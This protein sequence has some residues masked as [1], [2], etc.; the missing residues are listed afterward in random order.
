MTLA[1]IP[2]FDQIEQ[3][4]YWGLRMLG[5]HHLG[6]PWAWS[7]VL[8]TIAVRLL[9]VPVMVR[10]IHSMQAMRA[11]MPEM[12]RI[13]EQYK[14]DRTKK[15]EELMKFYRENKINPAASCLPILVQIPIFFALYLVLR[16]HIAPLSR[17][18][19]THPLSQVLAE[20][21]NLSWLGLIPDITQPITQYWAGYVLIVLYVIS[22]MAS[23]YYM[24]QSMERSQRI[25]MIFMPVVFVIFIIH[26]PVGGIKTGHKTH[27]VSGFPIGLMIY[28]VTTNLWTVGQ[29]LVTRQ[30]TPTPEPAPKRSSRTAPTQKPL[31]TAKAA[32]N[33]ARPTQPQVR[34]VKRK[35]KGGR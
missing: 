2:V 22:Q 8:L 25:L 1:S 20:R 16:H 18:T 11:H 32:P 12:K 17:V 21:P 27:Q 28:W 3:A 29:G 31:A 24:S 9:L 5:P 15:Q 13:Q 6:L 35:K 14:D 23:S 7:I 33:G 19:A 4:L 10:Q 30:L 34:R 26:P